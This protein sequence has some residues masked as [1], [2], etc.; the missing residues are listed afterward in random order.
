[1]AAMLSGDGG[2]ERG[3]DPE[4]EDARILREG[5]QHE[6]EL[7]ALREG[8]GEEK[9]LAPVDLE[10]PAQREEDEEFHDEQRNHETRDQA[11]LMR[12]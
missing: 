10:K 6:G 7:A 1:M 3:G 2:D 12:G 8:E 9:I 5:K 11:G 4:V